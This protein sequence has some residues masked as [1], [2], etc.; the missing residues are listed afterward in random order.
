VQNQ[1]TL[2]RLKKINS[3]YRVKIHVRDRKNGW[4]LALR[5]WD[6]LKNRRLNLDTTNLD[7]AM[8]VRSNVETQLVKLID[9]SFN[10]DQLKLS[11][12]LDKYLNDCRARQL[13]PR[14]IETIKWRIEN[15]QKK[16]GDLSLNQLN[17]E[18]LQ[19][20]FDGLI[21]DGR[22]VAGVAIDYRH[23]KASLNWAVERE[24][25]SENPI[26]RVKLPKVP[27]KIPKRL[28]KRELKRLF[29]VIN[30][31]Q[32]YNIAL[33]LTLTGLR[34]SELLNI[35]WR[36]VDFDDGILF[37]SN[38]KGG[39]QREIAIGSH[40]MDVLSKINRE[41]DLV[42]PGK[43][44]VGRGKGTVANGSM[45]YSRLHHRFREYF[46]LAEIEGVGKFHR[47]RHTTANAMVDK[48]YTEFDVRIFLGHADR[49]VTQG[50]MSLGS[51][52][53]RAIANSLEEWI[54]DLISSEF[55]PKIV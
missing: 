14:T 1:P 32:D 43:R 39:H 54:L 13:A 38:G 28:S 12:F 16:V 47:F 49:S 40:L 2:N 26:R 27:R 35:K 46:K 36:D 19:S 22:A 37:I 6:G 15:F 30:R 8:I 33:T 23:L 52:R 31:E 45:S 20:Y 7:T 18:L 50:Y 44:S 42:F 53:F 4:T 11:E 55:R 25:I 41:S 24:W 17:K 5:W 10:T 3:L 9:N 51:E 29:P 48:G 34:I 21:A